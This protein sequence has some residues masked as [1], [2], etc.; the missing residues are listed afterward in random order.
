MLEVRTLE[1]GNRHDLRVGRSPDA[2]DE[3]LFRDDGKGEYGYAHSYET[4]S[5]YDGP[6]LRVVLFVSG[7]LLRCTYCHNPDTW[8]LKDGT[9]I[10]AKQVLDR[11]AGFAPALKALD[12]GLTISGG[13]VM[14]QLA[15]TK[16]IL[17]GAKKM[18]LHTAIETSGFLGDRAGDDYLDALDLVLLDIK[19]SDP[20]TY[21]RVTGRDLAPTLRFAERLAALGKPVWVRFTLVPGLT[22]DPANVEG[23]ARFVAPMKN[24]EWV[25]VQPFHQLGAFK[26][27]AMGL[28]YKH[29]STPM[30]T[31]DLTERVIEQFKRA[32]CRAR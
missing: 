28:E 26:W 27:K 30:P 32:G 20:D 8:H 5:R 24:V 3:S 21:R 12:G 4:S 17:A 10:S 22:D 14:V 7:C 19:S 13:E 11:L 18:G 9:Y 23:V 6:G 2:P 25:E 16:R 31:P 29:A 1:P 15:F